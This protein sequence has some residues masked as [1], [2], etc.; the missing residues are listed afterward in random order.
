MKNICILLF[1]MFTSFSFSQDNLNKDMQTYLSNNGT[2]G[3]YAQVVDRMFDFLKNEYEGQQVSQELW[4]ELSSIKPKA[5]NDITNSIIQ[6]YKAHFSNEELTEML[7][8]YNSDVSKKAN[9]GVQLTDEEM[10]IQETFAESVLAKKIAKSSESLN[11]VLKN[12]TQEWS[13]QLF[14][15]VQAKLKAKGFTKQ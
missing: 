3:Y 7:S 14:L 15:D 1:L 13:A 9:S 10:K 4:E 2:L 11:N 8:Y 5:L 12:L 6:S